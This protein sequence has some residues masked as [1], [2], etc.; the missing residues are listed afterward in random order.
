MEQLK[1]VCVPGSLRSIACS[2]RQLSWSAFTGVDP[3]AL[4]DQPNQACLSFRESGMVAADVVGDRRKK[5]QHTDD[6]LGRNR[7]ICRAIRKS[8]DAPSPLNGEVKIDGTAACE[9]IVC[10]PST[11]RMAS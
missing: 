3:G 5:R 8:S 9:V 2:I 6:L 11:R 7:S 1:G 4:L 10:L